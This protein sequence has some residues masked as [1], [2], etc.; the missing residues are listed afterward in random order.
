MFLNLPAAP[1]TQTEQVVGFDR[2]RTVRLLVLPALFAEGDLLRRFTVQAL[3]LLDERG[4]DCALPDLPGLN[5]SLEPL[6]EQCLTTWKER[7]DCYLQ[8]FEATHCLTIRCGC[9]IAPA[10]HRTL[11]YAPQAG[12]A[13]LRPLLRSETVRRKENGEGATMEGLL[14]E[15][16][17]GGI[18][19]A[20][21]DL[22]SS[23]VEQLIDALPPAN[24]TVLDV[25]A[26]P[27]LWRAAEPAHDPTLAAILADAVLQATEPA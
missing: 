18:T 27:H 5:E 11:C 15:G 13:Q 12:M 10:G 16:R 1:R 7:V 6:E 14:E 4:I 3:C 25:P 23:M 21:F 2:G 19:L 9:L 20:G 8:A 17:T 22:R 26:A 24:A